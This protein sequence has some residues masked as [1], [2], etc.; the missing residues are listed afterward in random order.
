MTAASQTE[1]T[2]DTV[3]PATGEVIATFPVCG[4][5]EVEAAVQRAREAA[6]VVGRP[7]L[8]RSGGC[9]CWPGSRTSPGT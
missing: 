5:D 1:A 2:F 3:N 4:P 7:R 8:R 9:G 6:A